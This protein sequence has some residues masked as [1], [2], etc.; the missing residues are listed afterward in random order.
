MN[1]NEGLIIFF[2]KG[3]RVIGA[4][5]D[6]MKLFSLIWLV[7]SC[8]TLSIHNFVRQ[9]IM[10]LLRVRLCMCYCQDYIQNVQKTSI[11]LQNMQN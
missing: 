6:S 5:Q 4:M 10:Q 8:L 3:K 7:F 2:S 9:I 1:I 11:L